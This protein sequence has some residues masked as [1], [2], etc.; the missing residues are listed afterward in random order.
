MNNP[1]LLDFGTQPQRAFVT[2]PEIA[3]L[4]AM[5][6]NTNSKND[7]D[8]V[9]YD[10]I[11]VTSTTDAQPYLGAA[12]RAGV[13]TH[14][15]ALAREWSSATGA[16]SSMTIRKQ[17]PAYRAIVDLGWDAVPLLLKA[18]QDMPDL[19]FPALREITNENPV[20]LEH[21]GDYRKMTDAWIAWGRQRNLIS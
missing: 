1:G 16:H 2:L 15:V 21:R 11:V 12:V 3:W 14:F 17:H 6:K 5:P 19:W 10:V 13:R 8:R 9:P 20:P 7:G 4:F 18:L